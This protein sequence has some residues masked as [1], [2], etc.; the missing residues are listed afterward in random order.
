MKTKLILVRHGE[1]EGNS[2][3]ECQGWN[4]VCLTQKGCEQAK[5]VAERLKNEKIDVIYSSPFERALGTARYIAGE[6][7]LEIIVCDKLKE[8][9]FGQWEG[10]KWSY[11]E[12]N[13][14][15]ESEVWQNTP[16]IHVMP[17]GESVREVYERAVD[18]INEIIKD[19]AGKSICVVTHGT[20]LRVLMP[21]F[22]NKPFE[23]LHTI[24]W[25]VN[26]S[27]TIVEY[28]NKTFNVL[29]EGDQSHIG[30]RLSV[31]GGR[32]KI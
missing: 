24:S 6:K 21:Y 11:I 16:H 27:I 2:K 1:G 12:K 8:I 23:E 5:R 15:K 13:W 22:H 10:Q 30:E 9:N 20:I 26:T 14:Q 7:G 3:G 28:E 32:E 29:L 4:D 25:F 19:N 18:V 17:D 31:F